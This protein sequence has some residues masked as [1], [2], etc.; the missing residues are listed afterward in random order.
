MSSQDTKCHLIF[1]SKDECK[2][3][4]PPVCGVNGETYSSTCAAH[5]ARVIVDYQGQCKAVGDGD[6]EWQLSFSSFY[7]YIDLKGSHCY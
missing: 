4:S 2:P 1:V 6:G 5:S 7:C 3:P